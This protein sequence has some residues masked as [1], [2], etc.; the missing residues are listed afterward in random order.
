MPGARQTFSPPRKITLRAIYRATSPPPPPFSPLARG[1]SGPSGC[2]GR[3]TQHHHHPLDEAE[4]GIVPV[5]TQPTTHVRTI[6]I[7]VAYVLSRLS[8]YL[9][10]TATSSPPNAFNEITEHARR[11]KPTNGEPRSSIIALSAAIS[12]AAC[13]NA[14]EKAR[15]SAKK[16]RGADVWRAPRTC[17]SEKRPNCAFRIRWTAGRVFTTFSK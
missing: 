10:T 14:Q 4:A 15:G 7:A 3:S 5:D 13:G 6:A 9:T 11:L 17:G 1:T 2:T 16:S 8:A 12:E